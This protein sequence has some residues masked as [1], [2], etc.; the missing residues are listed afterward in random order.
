MSC[1]LLMWGAQGTTNTKKVATWYVYE[2]GK[3]SFSDLEPCKDIIASISVFGN[4]PK[5]FLDTCHRH[6]IEVYHAVS[7][8]ET[9][10]DSPQKINE[11]TNDYLKI[12]NTEGYDG[13]D[14]DFE[15]L[16]PRSRSNYSIFLQKTSTKLHKAGKKLSQCVGFYNTLYQNKNEEI[17]YDT[18]VLAETCDLVR[19]MCYDMYFAPGRGNEKLLDRIDCQGVGATSHYPFVKETMNFWTKYIPEEKLVMGLPAYSNDY[20]LENEGKGAQ[21]YKDKPESFKGVLP[22]PTW[23]WFEKINLYIY[24]GTD[25][26]THIFYASDARSTDSLLQL[27]DAFKITNIGFWHFS[28]VSNDMWETTRTWINK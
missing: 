28:T 6:K 4:P 15:A 17:F 11:L 10:I 9:D 27:A 16:H 20:V 5:S 26:Q 23:L 22:S 18:K 13:I 21:I 25:N 14:L 12:C 7:G 3:S 19:V 1:P 24:T 2:E 8:K